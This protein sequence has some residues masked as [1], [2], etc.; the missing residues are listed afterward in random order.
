VLFNVSNSSTSFL[1]SKN[2]YIDVAIRTRIRTTIITKAI[3]MNGFLGGG[4]TFG[5]MEIKG[6]KVVSVLM[7]LSV[8][9]ALY[10]DSISE[11]L[12]FFEAG[13][14][15]FFDQDNAPFWSFK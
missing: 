5:T 13:H 4:A 9:Q 2:K 6:S 12:C 3:A 1:F 15:N 8:A 10:I 7:K 11:R 14:A